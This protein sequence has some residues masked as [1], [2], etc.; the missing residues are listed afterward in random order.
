[1]SGSPSGPVPGIA[2]YIDVRSAKS[3][4]LSFDGELMAYL[5]DESG[6][7]QIWLKPAAG[8]A[9]WRLTQTDEPVTAIAFSPKSRDLIFTMDCGGDER[10]QLWLVPEASGQPVPLTQ[11][12]STVH[13]WGAWDPEGKRIAYAANSR[14]ASHM[15]VYVMDVATRKTVCVYEGTGWRQ[16]LAFFPDGSALLIQDS[17]RSMNDQDLVVLDLAT[18]KARNLL[19]HEGRAKYLAPRFKKDRSG[20]FLITDQGR[21]YQGLAFYDLARQQLDWVVTPER[22]IEA[23]ALASDQTRLAY[24]VN[25]DGWN[26]VV[27]RDCAS[28]A[29]TIAAGLPRGTVSSVAWRPDASA[30][31]LPLDGATSPPDI[32]QWNPVSGACERLTAASKAGLDLAGLVEPRVVE[33][34]SFD[35]LKVPFFLYEPRTPPPAGGYPVVVV[36]HGGPEAQ[37]TPIFRADVQYLLSRGVMVAAPNV[38]GSTGYGRAYQHLDDKLLRMDSVAD[39]KAVRDW[40]AAQSFVDARRLA[41]YGRSYGGFMVLAALTEYPSD[42]K[43]GIEFYGI[44]NFLTMLETTGPWRK[45][46]RAAEYGDPVADKE[47]LERFSPIH[48]AGR[49]KAP[50]LIAQGMDDPR[51]PPGESEMIYACLRGRGH[52]VDYIRIPHEGHGFARL[53][54][55]H[56][57]FGAVAAFL[58][59]HL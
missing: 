1:M 49:I 25:V 23:V 54:N 16:P 8:G 7:N 41:V 43:V 29:E 53:E 9:P 47:A 42:W 35:G 33:I 51:V 26:E 11:S 14:N 46:L 5:S 55:R 40:L 44:A 12:T 28:G 32:W 56:T 30:V 10:F 31:V 6:F 48:K 19:P 52:P 17:T 4:A 27:V 21:E 15:D 3:P 58:E 22:D 2:T 24:V 36:V 59:R 13:V 18:G 50:L 37:W 39:L 20:F 34:E 45:H 57:V 38:R